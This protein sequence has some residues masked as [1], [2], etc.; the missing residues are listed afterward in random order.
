MSDFLFAWTI[1]GYIILILL[2]SGVIFCLLLLKKQKKDALERTQ[3]FTNTAHD[4]RTPLA[5]IKAPLEEVI[6]NQELSE[7][8]LRQ[9]N[10][11]L[12][13]V[14]AI[15][16]LTTNLINL[17]HVDM[18]SSEL[19]ISEYEVSPYAEEICNSFKVYAEIKHIRLNYECHCEYLHVWF[20]RDKMDSIL[21]NV[22]SNALK[23]TPD[24]GCVDMCV[25]ESTEV[26]SVEV[27]DTGIG[28]PEDEQKDLFRFSFRASNALHSKV[29]GNGVGLM[30]V[31]KL[32]CMHKGKIY[33]NSALRQ[34]TTVKIEF[35]K[36]HKHFRRAHLVARQYPDA[37]LRMSRPDTF[38]RAHYSQS[39]NVDGGAESSEV[40]TEEMVEADKKFMA[41]VN[42]NIFENMANTEFNVDVV[43]AA[44]NMCR[45]NFYHKIKSLTGC[46]PSEYIR[47]VRLGH[48]AKLLE[49]GTLNVT[50]VAWMCGFNN[51]KYFREVFKKHFKVCP[52]RH[53]KERINQNNL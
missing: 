51:V 42:E 20:D 8:G 48:A 22:L 1:S 34:G 3:F 33:V 4:I 5:L 28:I 11:A 27:R 52:S 32:V 2:I 23:Y 7:E 43:C 6:S 16:R 41:L 13:N 24:G 29:R 47:N 45:T 25:D 37:L 49:E 10:M 12:T 39:V 31:H 46:S 40:K 26:W 36:G 30:L 19:Y 21:K 9:L 38:V 14:H 17:G 18:Y 15:L 44:V 53:G 50:E 35:P